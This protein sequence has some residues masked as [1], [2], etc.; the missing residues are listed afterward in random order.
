M[1]GDFDEGEI[2]VLEQRNTLNENL[3]D[4]DI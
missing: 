3:G 2:G 4:A 1:A